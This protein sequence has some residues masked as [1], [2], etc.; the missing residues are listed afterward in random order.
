MNGPG[1]ILPGLARRFG[2]KTALVTPDRR[3]TFVELDEL[4]D[5][6]AAGLTERGVRPGRP[7][8]LYAP[9]SWEWVVAYHGALKAGA[10]VN[11][12]NVMLTAEELAFVLRDCG[13]AAVLTTADQ[14]GRVAELTAD[15]PDLHSVVAFGDLPETRD[16]VVAFAALLDS[17]GPVPQVEPDPAQPCTI[18]YTSGTT[19]HPKGAVQSHRA[20]LWNC[21]ATATMHGR[22]ADDVVVTALPAPHVYGNV[23]I[24]GTFLVGGTVVLMPRFDPAQTLRLIAEHRATLFE[25][26]PAMY[27]M[28]LAHP[29][30]ADADLSSLTRCTVGG[31]TIPVSTVERWERRSGAPLIE[32]WGMTEISGLGTTHP[33]HAPPRPGSIGVSLPG[34]QVRIADLAD[35][36]RDAPVGEPGELMIRGPVVMLGYH[37]RPEATAE[38]LE[39]DGWLHTGDV[40][41]MDDAGY[42]FVVDRRK[43]MIITAGYNVYPAEIERVLA[44]HPGVA[45]V[46]AGPVPDPVKGELA[47]AYVVRTD[48]DTTTGAEL[49][50]Y[51][52]EHLAAYKVPR[53]VQFVDALPATS[54]GKIM[55]RELIKGFDVDS[56]VGTAVD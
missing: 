56:A 11:P 15:L 41:T 25:G 28:L 19:G 10:V 46:A 49:I 29:D 5:R 27:A 3:L 45:M 39:P 23:V 18:G 4:S 37:G 7:V 8:S 38:V 26:V 2:E 13:A 21:A 55:R 12:V 48:G 16:D 51:A 52:R 17:T 24:N 35:A 44:G 43:D 9:N 33:L 20:V 6:V 50:A 47:C 36:T 31:Q 54:T 53:L 32:L 40:A 14:A 1:E 42:V 30:L 22:S 34:V